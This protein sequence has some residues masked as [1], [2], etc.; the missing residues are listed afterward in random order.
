MV[1][2][3]LKQNTHMYTHTHTHTHTTLLYTQYFVITYS[4]KE[5]KTEYTYVY[6]HTHTHTPLCSIPETDTT[7]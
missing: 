2:K 3:N 6:T 5:S 4:G 7:L 1:E